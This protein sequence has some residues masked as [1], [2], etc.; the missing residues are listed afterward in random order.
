MSLW[1]YEQSEVKLNSRN[2]PD[3]GGISRLLESGI[4]YQE[5]KKIFF[6]KPKPLWLYYVSAIDINTYIIKILYICTDYNARRLTQKAANE[7]QKI[8]IHPA[9]GRLVNGIMC[10]TEKDTVPAGYA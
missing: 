3:E 2:N 10:A 5:S 1:F 9:D 4:R 7:K 8:I 6:K